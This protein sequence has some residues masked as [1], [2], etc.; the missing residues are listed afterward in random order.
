[1]A[2]ASAPHPTVLGLFL[3]LGI[4]ISGGRAGDLDDPKDQ[5]RQIEELIAKLGSQDFQERERAAHDL[6]AAGQPVLASLRR[7]AGE[8]K[9]VEIRRRAGFLVRRLENSL[10]E[11]LILFRSLELPLPPEKAPLV[12]YG[13]RLSP[14]EKDKGR[15]RLYS[16]GFLLEPYKSR[17]NPGTVLSGTYFGGLYQQHETHLANPFTAQAVEDIIRKI[18]PV[19]DYELPL[20]LQCKARGYDRLADAL[21]Q[22]AFPDEKKPVAGR[23]DSATSSSSRRTLLTEFGWAYWQSQLCHPDTDWNKIAPRLRK[24][25]ALE[26][27]LDDETNRLLMRSLTE[28]L[29][30]SNA[31]PGSIQAMIDDLIQ[32]GDTRVIYQGVD[33]RYLRLLEQGFAAVPELIEHLDDARLTQQ[34]FLGFNNF[35][36]FQL[37]V[38][39]LV[40]DLLEGLAGDELRRD[41]LP[42]QGHSL[43]KAAARFWWERARVIGE[44]K[45]MADHVLRDRAA[46]RPND[47]QLYLISKKFPHRLPAIYRKMLDERP[48]MQYGSWVASALAQSSVPASAKFDAFRYAMRKGDEDQRC[49]AL[50]ESRHAPEVFRAIMT[51]TL[52]ALAKAP[53]KRPATSLVGCLADRVAWTD[54]LLVWNAMNRFILTCDVAERML[55]LS[56]MDPEAPSR[57]AVNLLE[58][59]LDDK[60]VSNLNSMPETLDGEVFPTR[61]VGNVAALQLAA[62]LKISVQ[63]KPDWTADQWA[64]LRAEVRRAAK[65]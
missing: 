22:Q 28:A 24:L 7:A 32:C 20:I 34:Q 40:S 53:S 47:H 19:Y 44:E 62:R 43:E 51:E 16:L 12:L 52:N 36:P 9:D 5:T 57:Q 15:P 45:Y 26:P 65:R 37:R 58:T 18:A 14:G 3:L 48:A 56:R 50:R 11:L 41:G 42:Q 30:P 31:M 8:N 39:H 4:A 27:K 60:S 13:W 49:D 25:I 10:D 29:V 6:L 33:A 54:D 21:F 1:M 46:K 59:L 17:S 61:E 35:R 38:L 64:Q 2:A 55:V 63:P 23:S